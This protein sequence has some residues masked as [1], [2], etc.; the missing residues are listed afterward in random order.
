MLP[1]FWYT[2]HKFIS[3]HSFSI[4]WSH[5]LMLAARQK[6]N[7]ASQHQS[8]LRQRLCHSTESIFPSRGWVIWEIW[9]AAEITAFHLLFHGIRS[10]GDDVWGISSA[11]AAS[12]YLT[13]AKKRLKPPPPSFLQPSH[14]PLT[15]IHLILTRSRQAAYQLSAANDNQ[16]LPLFSPAQGPQCTVHCITFTWVQSKFFKCIRS[17]CRKVRRS[18]VYRSASNVSSTATFAI[19]A[20]SHPFTFPIAC[21]P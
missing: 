9:P 3:P 8:S 15:L 13:P 20:F 18:N 16:P 1:S 4:P 21:I 17:I 2:G 10:C 12:W 7:F 19:F 5:F 6:V 11:L 14:S